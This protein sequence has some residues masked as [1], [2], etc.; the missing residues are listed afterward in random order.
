[1]EE[2]CIVNEELR[3]WGEEWKDKVVEIYVELC[4]VNDKNVF[5]EE[6]LNIFVK[7]VEEFRF[8]IKEL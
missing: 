4:E 6:E 3:V 2:I 5:L 8:K 7:E 1:M